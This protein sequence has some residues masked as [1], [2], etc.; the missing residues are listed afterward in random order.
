MM[1]DFDEI[2]DPKNLCIDVREKL[3]KVIGAVSYLSW[4]T[5][6]TFTEKGGAVQM[7]AETPFVEDYVT[8]HFG[9]LFK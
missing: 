3:L 7:K 2:Y 1:D 5:K 6:V 4:F 8:T 9:H